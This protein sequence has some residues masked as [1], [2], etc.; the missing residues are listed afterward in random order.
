MNPAVPTALA[1]LRGNP[2]RRP[3]NAAEPRAPE[4]PAQMP[5]WLTLLDE[6]DNLEAMTVTALRRRC[7]DAGVEGCGRMRKAELVQALRSTTIGAHED[8]W[9]R[10]AAKLDPMG[11]LTRADEET[12][13]LLVDRIVE[14]LELREW[15]RLRGRTYVT[16]G[17]SGVMVRA[18]PQVKMRDQ[19]WKDIVAL[20]RE[21]GLTPAGRSR[22]KVEGIEPADP[23]DGLL[24]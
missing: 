22:I 3:L 15:V 5:P 1:Q 21:F 11:V 8:V 13:A 17:Q 19:A 24:D 9:R 23:L 12:F 4:G 7:R 10:I 18:Y 2:G 14:Y 20:G 6:Q 16:E